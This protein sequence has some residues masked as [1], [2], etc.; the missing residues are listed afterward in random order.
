MRSHVGNIPGYRFRDDGC[1]LLF[2]SASG[3]RV[4]GLGF[5]MSACFMCRHVHTTLAADLPF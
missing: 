5:N 2:G 1:R 4:E 3:F